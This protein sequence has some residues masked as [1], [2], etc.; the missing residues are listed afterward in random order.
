VLSKIATSVLFAVAVSSGAV[1][2]FKHYEKL[3]AQNAT[4]QANVVRLKEA[5][6]AE[7]VATGAAIK[8]I[9]DFAEAMRRNASDMMAL[10]ERT[11]TILSETRKIPDVLAKH[12]LATLLSR[13]QVLTLR[14]VNRGTERTW[15]LFERA[16][17]R[18]AY[19][20]TGAANAGANTVAEPGAR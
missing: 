13:K 17:A 2:L 8:R 18:G 4:L 20:A 1:A 6:E 5:V 15:R 9:D 14:A 11:N 7:K 16:T 10:S 3:V 19:D 12:D